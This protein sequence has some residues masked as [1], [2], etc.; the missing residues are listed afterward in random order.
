MS[1][2][3]ALVLAGGRIGG[4]F[5]EEAGTEIKGLVP[6]AGEP[7]LRRV[8]AALAA[9]PGVG[10]VVVVGPEAVREAVPEGVA[11]QREAETAFDNILAGF[12]A[13]RAPDEQRVL[14][15]GADVPALTPAAARDLLERAPGSADFVLPVVRMD[16]MLA[17]F[18]GGRDL[19]VP[20]REGPMTGGSQFVIRA[21]ALRRN[22]DLLLRLFAARKSQLAMAGTLGLP[23]IAR[24]LTRRLTIPDVERRASRLTGSECRAVPDCHPELAFDVDS[25]E[26][27]RF[28]RRWLAERAAP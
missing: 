15:C 24:L 22:R 12:E 18:P 1:S 3:D 28:I 20:L 5:A 25:L 13:L 26:D 23:F 9:T 14:V 21:G 17:H 7:M 11:W 27:F 2:V 4:G 19:Y 10:R 6:L 16:R 8:A